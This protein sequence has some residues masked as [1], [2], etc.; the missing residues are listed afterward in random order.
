VLFNALTI[1]V[2]FANTCA[3][4][5]CPVKF[6]SMRRE[7]NFAGVAPEDGTGAGYFFRMPLLGIGLTGRRLDFK[8]KSSLINRL[9]YHHP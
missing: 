8:R 2:F 1:T 6:M 7:A 5:A 4:P 3:C 9:K